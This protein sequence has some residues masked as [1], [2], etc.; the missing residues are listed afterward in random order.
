MHDIF[1]KLPWCPAQGSYYT[2]NRRTK[3]I[4][5]SGKEYREQAIEA[6]VEQNVYG[7]QVEGPLDFTVILYPPDKRIRDL[8]NHLKGLQDA[9]THAKVWVDDSAIFQLHPYR[10]VVTPQGAVLVKIS[11]G[12]G[13]IPLFPTVFDA[14][15]GL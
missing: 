2:T 7:L 3:Y 11:E 9:I 4:S 12:F 10:G 6:C 14:F 8:D 5:A 1:I 15:K 13:A